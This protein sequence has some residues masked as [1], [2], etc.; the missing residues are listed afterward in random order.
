MLMVNLPDISDREEKLIA[1]LL[2]PHGIAWNLAGTI[3]EILPSASLFASPGF[4]AVYEAILSV[5]RTRGRYTPEEVLAEM[6]KSASGGLDALGGE[7]AYWKIVA[8]FPPSQP[9]SQ[10]EVKVLAYQVRKAALLRGCTLTGRRLI[11]FAGSPETEALSEEEILKQ[12]EGTVRRLSL[13]FHPDTAKPL[14]SILP[15]ILEELSGKTRRP[16]PAFPF[17]GP[18]VPRQPGDIIVIGGR[19]GIGKT[20]LVCSIAYYAGVIGKEPILFFSCE[21]SAEQVGKR[22]LSLSTRIPLQRIMAGEVGD[23]LP[24][25]ETMYRN[26]FRAADT[27]LVNSSPFPTPASVAAQIRYFRHSTGGSLVIIDGFQRIRGDPREA[28]AT[29]SDLAVSLGMSII[30]TSQLSGRVEERNGKKPTLADLGAETP[31]LEQDA[32]AVVLIWREETGEI[33]PGF[34]P[35]PEVFARISRA[36]LLVVKNRHGPV[37]EREAEFDPISASFRFS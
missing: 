22:F 19:P 34:I 12:V 17:L 10:D 11:E 7:E 3:E 13:A 30:V 2:S 32:A 27:L 6:K 29:L 15:G 14:P 24:T 9:I 26:V 35:S 20:A 21:T 5:L 33:A 31:A 28:S 4:R 8:S 37:G 36:R 18:L 16:S 25:L 1:L 23:D